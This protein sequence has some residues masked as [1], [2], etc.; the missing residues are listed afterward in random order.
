MA[1]QAIKKLGSSDFSFGFLKKDSFFFKTIE[2]V[3]GKATTD[4]ILSAKTTKAE[5]LLVGDTKALG[6]LVYEKEL[7]KIDILKKNRT[8]FK[9]N[10]FGLIGEHLEGEK[11][12]QKMLFDRVVK[13]SK[14]VRAE[15]ILLDISNQS[16]NLTF[17]N[18]YGFSKIEDSNSSKN[19]FFQYLI[20][21]EDEHKT[22]KKRT[23]SA[24]SNSS[25]SYERPAKLQKTESSSTVTESIKSKAASTSSEKTELSH[26][27]PQLSRSKSESYLNHDKKGTPTTHSLPMKGTIYFEYIMS[28]VKKFEGRVCRYQ[29]SQM[30]VGDSLKMFDG[31]AGWGILCEITSVDK[32]LSFEQML[33][34]K[35]VVQMLPQLSE[36]KISAEALIREGVKIYE[37]FPGAQAVKQSGAIA[38]GVK[39]VKKI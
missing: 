9:L 31:R 33:R 21:S 39:F 5:V 19:C 16:K 35:G 2:N 10:N 26:T 23:L 36:K 34:A 27:H 15:G 20:N 6:L 38:I 13:L 32:Y 30:K 18:D 3:L 1:I 37:S 17:S 24:S 14:R 7:F 22:G 11:A 29:C 12:Y 28:G 8:L 25:D 4:Q